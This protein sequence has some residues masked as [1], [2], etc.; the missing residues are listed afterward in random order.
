MNYQVGMNQIEPQATGN[1]MP[2]PLFILALPKSF[3]SVFGSC[4]GQHPGIMGV[5]ELNMFVGDTVHDWAY[6]PA[7][8]QLNG[9]F[10]DGLLRTLAQLKFGG[11]TEQTVAQA[12]QWLVDRVD[13]PIRDVFEELRKLSAPSIL[14]DQ[15][16][17][18]TASPRHIFR[19]L[20]AYPNAK[21]IHLTRNP[22]SWI[23]SIADW[24]MFGEVLLGLFRNEEQGLARQ[25]DPIEIWHAANEGI[26]AVLADLPP[27]QSIRVRGEDVLTDFDPQMKRVLEFLNLDTSDASMAELHHPERSVYANLGPRGARFGNNPN[28]LKEPKLKLKSPEDLEKLITM[29]RDMVEIPEET[30]Q[31]A[32]TMGYK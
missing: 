10:R 1:D 25:P 9:A 22:T 8:Q 13:W 15:S 3:T 20:E 26:A 24:R 27:E 21:F 31:F 18:Y 2:E 23:K 14:L 30:I 17:P 4:L 6:Q 12:E 29:K 7:N 11:Q 32:A 5:P 19:L 16:P 28:F